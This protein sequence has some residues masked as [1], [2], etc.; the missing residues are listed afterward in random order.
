M[1]QFG[2]FEIEDV[3]FEDSLSI[4]LPPPAA[5]PRPPPPPPPPPAIV[6]G[7]YKSGDGVKHM[8]A[9]AKSKMQG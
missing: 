6:G 2:L 4:P 5:P 9:M 3:D 8:A 7:G 1:Q